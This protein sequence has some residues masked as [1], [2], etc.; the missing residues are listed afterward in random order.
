VQLEAGRAFSYTYAR[1]R[2]G[3]AN[4]AVLVPA[5]DRSYAIDTVVAA[6]ANDAARELGAIVRSFDLK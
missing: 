3:T 4:S 1:T 6:G 5:G 2:T